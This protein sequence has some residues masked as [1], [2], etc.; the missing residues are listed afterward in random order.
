MLGNNYLFRH[1]PRA[2]Q[3][4]LF[5]CRE[6]ITLTAREQLDPIG[7]PIHYLYFPLTAAISVLH[8]DLQSGRG[9]EGAVIGPEGCTSSYFTEGLKSSPCQTL[10]QVGGLA[11]RV[12]VKDLMSRLPKL[13]IF[14]RMVR[15]FN[16][17]IYRH[18]ILSLGCNHFHSVEQ[19]LGRWLLAHH[20]RTGLKELAFTH[21]FLSQQLGVQRVTVTKIL[22][23]LQKQGI[24]AYAY[25][26]LELQNVGALKKIACE[27]FSLAKQAIDDYLTEIR[28]YRS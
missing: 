23:A 28:S 26:K 5:P 25:G 21:D 16:G 8:M 6:L 1:L 4:L 11:Y 10:I 9:V 15:R 27:C 3:R 17:V 24:V 18:I 20:H 2:E 19:R 13:P 22:T 7:H 14:E 12:G